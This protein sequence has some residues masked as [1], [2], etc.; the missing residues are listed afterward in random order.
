[1]IPGY[2]FDSRENAHQIEARR[3]ASATILGDGSVMTGD[4]ARHGRDSRAVRDQL[5]HGAN[6][7]SACCLHVSILVVLLYFVV[8]APPAPC[9]WN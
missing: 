3:R 5:K 8:A 6:I 9:H 2:L 7:K 4:D 1:M